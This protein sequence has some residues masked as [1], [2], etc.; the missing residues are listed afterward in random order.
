MLNVMASES[1]LILDKGF[2]SDGDIGIELGGSRGVDIEQSVLWP[3]GIFSS[4][5]C[6]RMVRGSHIVY[7]A[8]GGIEAREVGPGSQAGDP[9]IKTLAADSRWRLANPQLEEYEQ[10][11]VRYSAS[12]MAEK[13]SIRPFA[14][15][16]D[17]HMPTLESGR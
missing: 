13:L 8:T 4:S 1:I 9:R 15:S 7:S 10:G 12:S 2:I 5:R 11:R 17:G 6:V 14:V 3:S 16:E